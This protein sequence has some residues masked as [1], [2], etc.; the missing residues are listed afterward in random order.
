[1][2]PKLRA[3]LLVAGFFLLGALGGVAAGRAYTQ[4]ELAQN[5]F[6]ADPQTREAMFLNAMSHE[7][8]LSDVQRSQV[9]TIHE[10][11]KAQR[12]ELM[13]HIFQGCG[14]PLEELQTT[15]DAEMNAVLD[16]NQAARWRQMVAHRRQH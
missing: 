14:K 1:V 6:A 2:S 10:K 12:R 11:H 8:G 3:Y 7:L 9:A 15:M 4:R 5:L 13:R 16:A